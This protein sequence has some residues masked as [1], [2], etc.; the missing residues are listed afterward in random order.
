LAAA[1]SGSTGDRAIPAGA[2]VVAR[3]RLASAKVKG[4][5]IIMVGSR[6]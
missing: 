5:A 1:A 6:G 2:T 3:T 4:L